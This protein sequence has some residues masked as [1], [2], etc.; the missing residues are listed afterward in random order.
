MS[1][2]VIVQEYASKRTNMPSIRQVFAK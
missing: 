1:D 2:F